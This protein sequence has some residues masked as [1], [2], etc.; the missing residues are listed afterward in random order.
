MNCVSFEISYRPNYE[1]IV[2]TPDYADIIIT[3]TSQYSGP[4][5]V[6]IQDGKVKFECADNIQVQVRDLINPDNDFCEVQTSE[7]IEQSDID[8]IEM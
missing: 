1:I 5:F 3:H 8:C 6:I 4:I 2:H 7:I